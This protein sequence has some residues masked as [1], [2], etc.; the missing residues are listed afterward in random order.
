M[1][2]KQTAP[3]NDE[4]KDDVVAG[5]D[6]GAKPADVNFAPANPGENMTTFVPGKNWKLGQIL[7]GKYVRTER[8]YSNKFTAGKKDAEGKTYR[9]LHILEDLTN[10]SLFG[11][12]S[13]GI[14]GNFFEQTPD[15]APVSITYKGLAD[16]PIQAGQ[17][18]PHAFDFALGEGF[19]LQRRS[20]GTENT[21]AA[22]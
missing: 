10:K 17:S 5:K 16:K 12:W 11:I 3:A 13:V 20:T 9:D 7:T 2:K 1:T 19:R 22:H 6:I 21:A 18:V 15:E 8:V 4:V 14:L